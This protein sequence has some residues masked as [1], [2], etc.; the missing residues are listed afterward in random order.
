MHV[1][2][3]KWWIKIA[4]ISQ[5]LRKPRDKYYYFYG[6]QSP[7]IEDCFALKKKIKELIKQ[8][9]LQRFLGRDRRED[10]HEC[11]FSTYYQVR[12]PRGASREEDRQEC[13]FSTYY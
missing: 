11:P 2:L 6:D 10:R 9:R 4:Q 12:H 13:P 5:N 3:C 1:T 8:G 7:N